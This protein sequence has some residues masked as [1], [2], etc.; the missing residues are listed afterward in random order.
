MAETDINV[1]KDLIVITN[2]SL[3]KGDYLEKLREVMM[4]HPCACILREK[5]LS[6]DEYSELAERVQD[7]CFEYDVPFF[8]HG[9]PDTALEIGCRNIHLPVWAVMSADKKALKEDFDRISV[10]CHSVED[11]EKALF[12]GATQIVLGTIYETECKKGLKGRGTDF[13]KEVCDMCP[14][15]VYAIGG[16]TPENLKDVMDSGAAGGCMMSGFMCY[17]A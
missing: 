14:V 15:P 9:H 6:D 11:V 10:S 8:V 3:V 16:I 17:S 7:I 2:R 4:L 12:C 1:Y 13:V 5:D